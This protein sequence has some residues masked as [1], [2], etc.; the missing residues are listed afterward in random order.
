[1]RRSVLTVCGIL[2]GSSVLLGACGAPNGEGHEEAATE[3]ASSPDPVQPGPT[4]TLEPTSEAYTRPAPEELA[5]QRPNELGW[6]PIL[7]Y[8]HFEPNASQ[9][10]RTPE[11]FRRDLEWLYRNDFYVIG[12]H[13]YLDG[14]FDV[15]LGKHPVILTFDDAPATQFRLLPRSDGK[16]HID[17]KTAVGI[18]EQFFK[19]HPDFGRG[20][21]FA[22][23]PDRTFAWSNVRENDKR[24]FEYAGT[25]LYWLMKNGYEIGN[26][27]E[28]HADLSTLERKEVERELAT[29]N[30][31]LMEQAPGVEIR[32]VTLP[33]G[34]YPKDGD[35]VF[36]GFTYQGNEYAF[37]GVLQVGANPALSPYSA[38]CDKYAI[39]RIQA[40][41]EQLSYWFE[42]MEDNPGIIFTSDGDP[43]TVTVPREL[44]GGLAGTLDESRLEGR[45]LIRY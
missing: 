29:A 32:V 3:P 41:S 44:P 12:V 10:V 6:I 28:N 25:K 23:L 8:H 22:I 16:L 1:M 40:F 2:L 36:R 38:E 34:A 31:S 15:P 45:E 7:Q 24:Q 35:D 19:D 4:A 18:M 5:D 42:F 27:T 14:H 33:Y 20:G 17:T 13:D 26:H 39:P 30:Q 43:D 21:H 11:Q 9:F 37:D